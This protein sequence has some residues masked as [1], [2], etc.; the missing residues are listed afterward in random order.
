[1]NIKGIINVSGKSGLYKI[2]SQSEKSAI[3]ES[4]I[5]GK[6]MP[7]YSHTSANALE[8]IGLL[9]ITTPIVKIIIII[10]FVFIFFSYP[11][12]IQQAKLHQTH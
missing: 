1:M 4:L 2:I 12:L 9:G 6:K 11:E 10:I 3:V 7:V 8:E 5:D